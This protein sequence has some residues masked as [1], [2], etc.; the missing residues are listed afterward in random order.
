MLQ[1]IAYNE[2]LKVFNTQE[3][4]EL[5]EQ[6]QAEDFNGTLASVSQLKK[7]APKQEPLFEVRS[8]KNTY[9]NGEKFTMTLADPS[10][11]KLCDDIIIYTR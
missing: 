6:T 1:Q 11:Y 7:V 5:F 9:F 4:K 3:E 2:G 10:S 8:H